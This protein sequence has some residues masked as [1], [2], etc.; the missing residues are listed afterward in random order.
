VSESNDEDARRL[1]KVWTVVLCLVAL[2]L[3][4]APYP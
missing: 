4:H 2:I 1:N 3:V